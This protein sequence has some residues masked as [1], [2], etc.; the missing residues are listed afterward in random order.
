MTNKHK[1]RCSAS[2]TYNIRTLNNEDNLKTSKFLILHLKDVY[3]KIFTMN[4][5]WNSSKS[6]MDRN[7]EKTRQ[8]LNMCSQEIV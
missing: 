1:G 6:N 8:T 7:K 2:L 5:A 4:V 3:I